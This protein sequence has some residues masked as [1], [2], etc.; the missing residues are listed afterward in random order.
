MKKYS[1]IFVLP[2][3]A[4]FMIGFIIPFIMGIYLSFCK[5][6]TVIDAELVGISNYLKVFRLPEHLFVLVQPAAADGVPDGC[7]AGN[8]QSHIVLCP[9][10]EEICRFLVKVVGLPQTERC[11]P[12]GTG[13]C[14]S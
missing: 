3:F 12:W 14:G 8:N 2:T 7:N 11:R 6:T 1:P 10:Q 5:F 13:R 4:A 9:F